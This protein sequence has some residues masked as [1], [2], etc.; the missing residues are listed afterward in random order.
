MDEPKETF[1]R[2][3]KNVVIMSFD[4]LHSLEIEDIPEATGQA[5]HIIIFDGFLVFN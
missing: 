3:F 5:V 2:F 4:L 1:E